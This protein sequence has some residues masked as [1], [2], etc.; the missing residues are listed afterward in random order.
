VGYDFSDSAF[1]I[2]G[3]ASVSSSRPTVLELGPVRPNPSRGATFVGFALPRD[4]RVRVSVHDVLGREV[5]MLAD[6][7]YA[8]GR[9]EVRWNGAREARAGL[10]F[11]RMTAAGKTLIHRVALVR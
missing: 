9:Y 10:Y 5:A 3:T 2:A 1:S 6:G 4:A 8:A 11:V 7:V